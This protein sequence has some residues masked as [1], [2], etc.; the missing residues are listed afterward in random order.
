MPTEPLATAISRLA[1]QS[2]ASQRQ[3]NAVRETGNGPVNEPA[4]AG[5]SADRSPNRSSDGPFGSSSYQFTTGV[6][7]GE[8]ATIRTPEGRVLLSYRSFATVVG[9]IATLVSAIVLFAGI[10]GALFLIAENAPLRAVAAL[11]LTFAFAFVI[12]LLVPRANVTLFD[13]GRAALALSQLSVFPTA[14][15]LVTTPD[16][17]VLAEVRKSIWSRLGR[18][19]WTL[20]DGGRFVGQ[21]VEESFGRALMRK[22]A[23]KF[24]RRCETDVVI[25]SG[26]LET[27]RIYRRPNAIAVDRLEVHGT[28]LDRRVAVALATLILGREP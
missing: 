10:A 4:H 9:V 1:S 15:W 27:G 16:G 5:G 17:S 2:A 24:S 25:E 18:N 3:T 14:R 19:R 13:D 28:L 6:R 11:A 22:I 26:G 21:A 8:I 23:G 7:A 12:A 20:I